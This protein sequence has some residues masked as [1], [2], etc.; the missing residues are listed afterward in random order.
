MG[1]CTLLGTAS[2]TLR[3]LTIS[4]FVMRDEYLT[5]LAI[6]NKDYSACRVRVF[7]RRVIPPWDEKTSFTLQLVSSFP[8]SERRWH[9]WEVNDAVVKHVVEAFYKYMLNLKDGGVID[10]AKV[11][12]ALACATYAVKTKVPLEQ[13]LLVHVSV[14]QVVEVIYMILMASRSVVI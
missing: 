2:R 4:H 7:C 9:L 8:G 10:C 14:H 12:R 6:M 13:I 5:L 11:A 3:S 1:K